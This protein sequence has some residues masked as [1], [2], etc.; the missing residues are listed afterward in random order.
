MAIAPRGITTILRQAALAAACVALFA[1]RGALAHPFPPGAQAEHVKQIGFSKLDGRFGGFKIAIKHTAND[2]WYL[3]VGHSFNQ[4][5]SIVDVTN[6]AKPRYVKFIPYV[7]DDKNVITSQVTLH[8][9]LLL[10]SLN[11]FEPQQN[12]LPA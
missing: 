6:P 11:T 7:T 4:G 1:P 2:K 10:T 8:D 9:N 3:Y 12:P 5:W